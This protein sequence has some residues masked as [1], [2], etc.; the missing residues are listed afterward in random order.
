MK[1]YPP[2]KLMVFVDDITAI[3]EGRSEE[4]PGIAEKI[5]RAMIMEVLEKGL[6]LPITGGR[7]EGESQ[8]SGGEKS[9]MQQQRRSMTCNQFGH[10]SSRLEDENEAAGSK[11]A[12]EK[13]EL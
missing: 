7:K 3:T 6:E 4:L 5:V 13:E 12:G 1:V 10:I 9:G 2:L 11:G 8:S